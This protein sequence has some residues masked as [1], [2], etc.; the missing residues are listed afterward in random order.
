MQPCLYVYR[1]LARISEGRAG[2]RR[3]RTRL[4]TR[5]AF[6]LAALA[7]LLA[8]AGNAQADCFTDAARYHHVNPLVLRAI[9]LVESGGNPKAINHNRNGSVDLGELQINSIHQRELARYGIAPPDLLD[10]CKNIYIGAWILRGRMDQY[11]NTWEAI[12][13]YHSATPAYR[14]RYV[15]RVQQAIRALLDAGY[16]AR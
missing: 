15:Q 7:A 3:G 2:T 9:A 16:G 8:L 4:A 6:L 1:R 13:A 12:G 11:G 10:A 14:D 5:L